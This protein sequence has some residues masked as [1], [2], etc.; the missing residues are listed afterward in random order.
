MTKHH[1]N[2]SSHCY[3]IYGG[4]MGHFLDTERGSYQMPA[5]EVVPQQH[6]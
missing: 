5:T 4:S 2:K 1:F 6:L 3:N